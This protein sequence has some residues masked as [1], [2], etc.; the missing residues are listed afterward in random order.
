M[1]FFVCNY[2][3]YLEALKLCGIDKLKVKNHV[4]WVTEL[5]VNN[6]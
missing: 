6:A 5:D 4:S 1:Y 2:V 3:M